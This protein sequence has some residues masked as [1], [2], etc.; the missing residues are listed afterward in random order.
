M[1][2]FML[3]YDFIEIG[4]VKEMYGMKR[5]GAKKMKRGN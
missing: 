4:K 2:G 3:T 5:I 1:W